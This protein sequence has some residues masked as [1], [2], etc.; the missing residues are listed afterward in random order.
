MQYKA[1]R[2]EVT[3]DNERPC[4]SNLNYLLQSTVHSLEYTTLYSLLSLFSNQSKTGA[5][6][7]HN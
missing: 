1:V 6:R 4:Q 2:Y 7:L 5:E 3:G